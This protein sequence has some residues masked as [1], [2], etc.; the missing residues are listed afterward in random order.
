MGL[1][2]M[3]VRGIG[4]ISTVILARLLVPADFG[5]I[6][7][8]TSIIAGLQLATAF[9]FD[10]P[11]IQN[12]NADRSYF[13]SAWTLNVLFYAALTLVLVLLAPAAAAFYQDERLEVVIH[14]LAIGFFVQGFENIGIVYFRKELD[15]RQDFI[16]MLSKKLGGFLITVPLAYFLRSYWALIAGMVTGNAL[17]VLLSYALHPFRPRLSLAA[18][19]QLFSFSKWLMLNNI[20]NFLCTRSPDF[21]IGRISG[22]AMLGFFTVAHEI[23][24]LPTTELVAPINR[25]VFPAYSK[26]AG[27]VSSL[28]QSYI[29]VLTVIAAIALPAGFGIAAVATPLV[30]VFLGD[31]WAQVAPIVSILAIFGGISSLH[32]NTGSLFN[33]IAKPHLITVIGVIDISVLV[34]SSIILAMHF[35]PLGV[36]VAYLGTALLRTPLVFWY[37]GRET[38]LKA[39][40]LSAA[41][42]RPTV[43]SLFMYAAV[44]QLAMLAPIGDFK[45][46]VQLIVLALVGA[47][48]YLTTMLGLWL[49]AGRPTSADYRLVTA[50]LARLRSNG[51][52]PTPTSS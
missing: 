41:L 31:K 42:W 18:V 10:I 1:L 34:T 27:N 22:P 45:S 38:Q 35:G 43:C 21:I 40:A 44:Q 19:G 24:T 28:R 36:A 47:A 26:L 15:F 7:M 13:D 14:V 9:S 37:V 4:L 52:Q 3:L 17:G 6:A 20:V 48:V 46:W 29:D 33:A 16:L 51:H 12:Q 32:S 30:D 8:A 50:M 23:S 25:V 2:R 11:L 39:R 49:M 5:L